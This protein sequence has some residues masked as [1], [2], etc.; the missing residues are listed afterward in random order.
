MANPSGVPGQKPSSYQVDA[1]NI[2][3]MARLIRQARMLSEHLGLVPA[4]LDLTRAESILDIGCGPGEWVLQMAR[5]FPTS[6]VTGIDIS[7]QMIAYAQ[8]DAQAHQLSNVQ[9]Q[10]MDARGPLAFPDASFDAIH[11]RFIT[12]FLSTV[13]WPQLVWE[14]FRLLRPGGWLVSIEFEDLGVST[15]AALTEY[16]HLLVQA[17]RRAGQCFSP[18]GDHYGITAVQHRLLQEAGFQDIHQQA[19][20]I[21]YSAGMPAHIAMTENFRTFLSLVQPFLVRSGVTTQDEIRV[22]YARVLEEM[23]A[24][25]FSAVA[26][27]HRVW[28]EK[29]KET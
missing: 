12:G 13:T 1:E 9:F 6:R 17:A 5:R 19:Y 14:C 15:S 27:F 10:V 29:P 7:E 22:L 2:A 20:S 26:Y 11:A 25:T 16:N 18:A 28:G 21:N 24:G 8:D 4:G 3:E 23:H